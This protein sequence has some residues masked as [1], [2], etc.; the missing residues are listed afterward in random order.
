MTAVLINPGTGYVAGAHAHDARANVRAFRRELELAMPHVV[1]D[2]WPRDDDGD[3]RYGFVLRRGARAVSVSMP[4]LPLDRVALRPGVSAWGFPRLYVDG[5]SWLWPF[6]LSCARDAL[7]DHDGA[8][9]RRYAQ[10][11]RA[12]QRALA[13]TPRCGVCGAIKDCY[14]SPTAE[15]PPHG[16][17]RLRCLV[18]TPVDRTAV[19]SYDLRAVYGDDSW[20][21]LQHGAVYRRTLRLMP[22]EA[23][24]TAEDPRC[25]LGLLWGRYCR[26]RAGHPGV[27]QGREQEVA[28]ERIE[29]P[30]RG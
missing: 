4:G 1:I 11:R 8:A 19:W 16:Y 21:A 3:G 20:K 24:G 29:L 17:V 12:C 7:I 23:L 26:L 22:N 18:C 27:C 2:R 6:A 28:R 14:T 25:V 13:T 30:W 15:N 9:A 5:S 10:S